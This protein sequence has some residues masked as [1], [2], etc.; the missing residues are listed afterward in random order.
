MFCFP[1]PTE[2][3]TGLFRKNWSYCVQTALNT[4]FALKMQLTIRRQLCVCF[5]S[6]D[7]ADKPAEPYVLYFQKFPVK[8]LPWHWNFVSDLAK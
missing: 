3:W 2:E 7:L 8:H 4:S 1:H 6:Q 5:D